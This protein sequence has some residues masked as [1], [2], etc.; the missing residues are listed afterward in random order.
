MGDSLS[1]S[2]T[3]RP[4][5]PP[6]TQEALP[7]TEMSQQSMSLRQSSIRDVH[8]YTV[9]QTITVRRRSSPDQRKPA[10]RP[11]LVLL[12]AFPLGAGTQAHQACALDRDCKEDLCQTDRRAPSLFVAAWI[13]RASSHTTSPRAKTTKALDYNDSIAFSLMACMM[14]Y[15][16]IH[17]IIESSAQLQIAE[18]FPCLVFSLQA[19][20]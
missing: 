1:Q 7:P 18:K 20:A 15:L 12:L 9:L 5:L 19:P 3:D 16:T 17:P 8:E 6:P 14:S 2:A 11:P 4:S 10:E 13:G